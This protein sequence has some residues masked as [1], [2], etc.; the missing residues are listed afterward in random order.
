MKLLFGRTRTSRYRLG[1][2]VCC[3]LLMGCGMTQV[4]DYTDKELCDS[5]HSTRPIEPLRAL[6]AI[7]TLGLSEIIESPVARRHQELEQEISARGLKDNC[8]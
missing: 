5:W 8:N 6:E 7:T 3:L 4:K 1:F 2:F